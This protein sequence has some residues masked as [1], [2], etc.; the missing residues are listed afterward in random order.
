MIVRPG[1]PS[2]SRHMDMSLLK[3]FKGFLYLARKD[4]PPK[5]IGKE[6]SNSSFMEI[7]LLVWLH[8]KTDD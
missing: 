6:L 7:Q 5:K 2:G 1:P 8:H 4:F 3:M